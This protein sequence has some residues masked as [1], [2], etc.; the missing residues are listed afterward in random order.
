MEFTTDGTLITKALAKLARVAEREVELISLHA[1]HFSQL[2]IHAAGLQ[3]RSMIV[4][5]A[6][7]AKPG[8]VNIERD[9]FAGI[10]RNRKGLSFT[11]NNNRMDFNQVGTQYRG[12]G[13]SVLPF[14]DTDLLNIDLK[15]VMPEHLQKQFL[16]ALKACLITSVFNS[17]QLGLTLQVTK[18]QLQIIIA[19]SYHAA[20][21]GFDITTDDR[22]RLKRSGLQEPVILPATYAEILAKQFS[23]TGLRLQVD[24]RRVRFAN[25]E[26]QLE[27]PALQS[28]HGLLA[29][30]LRLDQEF[31]HNS[32]EIPQAERLAQILDNIK[33][34]RKSNEP[35][36]L[37]TKRRDKTLRISYR[38]PSGRIDD[39]IE[40]PNPAPESLL[41]RLEP[42]NYY[43]VAR[44][45][46][47]TV[48]MTAA[49]FIVRFT[50]DLPDGVRVNYYS[51]QIQPSKHSK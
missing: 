26:L 11:I 43:D 49:R 31:G 39:S 50:R 46:S 14:K 24:T 36:I 41:L 16:P 12:R 42:N 20:I 22:R 37:R 30:A 19:D 47:G 21:A 35:I 25:E 34:I 5:P 13:I 8:M 44:K 29:E 9:K 32:I 33:T 4:V 6:T 27:L 23:K 17:Q 3:R 1:N 18:R 48:T 2:E 10:C 15:Q 40:L 7:V 51:S 45:L 38:A 28:N